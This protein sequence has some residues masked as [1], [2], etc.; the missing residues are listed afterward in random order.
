MAKGKTLS[1]FL[2]SGFHKEFLVSKFLAENIVWDKSFKIFNEKYI[3]TFI[4]FGCIVYSGMFD[5]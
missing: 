1:L 5:I 2:V 4:S 3:C